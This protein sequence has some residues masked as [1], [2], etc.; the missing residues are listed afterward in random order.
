[1]KKSV[2][3][4]KLDRL[5][6]TEEQLYEY[7]ELKHDLYPLPLF[8]K[9]PD[10]SYQIVRKL[11]DVMD[12]KG[13]VTERGVFLYEQIVLD[14]S[15]TYRYAD[16]VVLAQQI[17]PKAR[18]LTHDD[19]YG[20]GQNLSDLVDEESPLYMTN[21]QLAINRG[22]EGLGFSWA[23]FEDDNPEQ[24]SIVLCNIVG[25]TETFPIS[26]VEKIH[27]FIPVAELGYDFKAIS[28][29]QKSEKHGLDVGIGVDGCD[30]PIKQT[31]DS[32]SDFPV[33]LFLRNEKGDY[34]V[35]KG[36]CNGCTVE[37]VALHETIILR[38]TINPSKLEKVDPTQDDLIE[39]AKQ[40]HPKAKPL[41]FDGF[42]FGGGI[43]T[44]LLVDKKRYNKTAEILRKHGVVMP[45]INK[46]LPFIGGGYSQTNRVN[47]INVGW[48]V[49]GS[50][51]K[52]VKEMILAIPRGEV[53][54]YY[55]NY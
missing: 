34:F 13:I 11:N 43:V 37:G 10:N 53:D 32:K 52:L 39:L 42:P 27:V 54:G 35:S 5:N 18:P 29:E 21:Q 17:H 46:E 50:S 45:C 1:M 6:P 3:F 7:I 19:A 9:L 2:L 51:I 4:E 40:V 44:L 41:Y 8:V 49:G 47:I 31:D 38:Q 33:P 25:G 23:F 22:V 20:E 15:K 26:H 30:F 48:W 12:V 36:M 28:Q 55:H 16:L 24:T 14:K